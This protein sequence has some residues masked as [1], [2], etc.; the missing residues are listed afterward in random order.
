VFKISATNRFEA[1]VSFLRKKLG[2][3]REESVFCYVNSVF[4]PGLDEGVGGLWKV[5]L[6]EGVCKG[7]GEGR[8]ICGGFQYGVGR[9]LRGGGRGRGGN[10]RERWVKELGGWGWGGGR[11]SDEQGADYLGFSASKRDSRAMSSLSLD[12]R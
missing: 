3:G 9:T 5:S 2:V 10:G 8:R 1:V 12:I 4:A 11:G 7:R 6:F